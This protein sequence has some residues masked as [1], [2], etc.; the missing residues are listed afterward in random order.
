MGK[1]LGHRV[2]YG[3]NSLYSCIHIYSIIR[4]ELTDG[5]KNLS[6]GCSPPSSF[7]HIGGSKSIG[8]K[9]LRGHEFDVRT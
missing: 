2:V 1:K 9:D 5:R 6:R 7:T 4:M 3:I 8:F